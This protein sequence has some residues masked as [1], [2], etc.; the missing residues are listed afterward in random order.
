MLFD[1]PGDFPVLALVRRVDP[2]HRPLKLGEFA[3]HVGEEVG[4][5][6][7]RRPRDARRVG[8]PEGGRKPRAEAGYPLRLILQAPEPLVEHDGVELRVE[9]VEPCL[10]VL[11]EKEAGVREA[12]PEHLFVPPYHLGGVGREC[13]GEENE[14]SLQ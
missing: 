11:V 5:D 13:V 4:L 6:E 3:H 7:H 9:R 8:Y 2:A 12:R 14:G 10:F 1:R